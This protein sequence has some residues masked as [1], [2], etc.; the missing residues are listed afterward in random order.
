MG[1]VIHTLPA[2]QALRDAFPDATIG[3]LIEERWADLLCAPGTSRRETAFGT[4]TSGR[5]GTYRELVGWRKSLFTIPTIEQ[6]ASVWNDV[7]ACEVRRR[8]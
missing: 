8:D 7:R 4:A 2:A 6:I 1:D 3:W 5:L